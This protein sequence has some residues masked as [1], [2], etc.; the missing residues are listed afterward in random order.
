[1]EGDWVDQDEDVEESARERIF[2]HPKLAQLEREHYDTASWCMDYR[3][4]PLRRLLRHIHSW[5]K[6]KFISGLILKDWQDIVL[7]IIRKKIN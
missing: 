1:V 2:Q 3:V 4:R 6:C 7:L 5:K